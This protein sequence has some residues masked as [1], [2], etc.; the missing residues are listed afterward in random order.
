MADALRWL[1][2]RG[3]LAL[4]VQAPVALAPLLQSGQDGLEDRGGLREKV[5]P[6]V[7]AQEPWVR[8]WRPASRRSPA[9]EG[10]L[11]VF[12]QNR[13]GTVDLWF[14]TGQSSCTR[15]SGRLDARGLALKRLDD[16]GWLLGMRIYAWDQ[17]GYELEVLERLSPRAELGQTL[18]GR[19]RRAPAGGLL[20]A[21][22]ASLAAEAAAL[23]PYVG[24]FRDAEGGDGGDGPVTLACRP[25]LDGTWLF[26]EGRPGG[27]E[28]AGGAPFELACR[29]PAG[30]MVVHVFEG[31][32]TAREYRGRLD[33]AGA[34]LEA[35]GH[36]GASAWRRSDVF[37]QD[38]FTRTEERRAGPEQEWL[39][40]SSARFRRVPPGQRP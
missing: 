16:S 33:S 22:E 26:A 32:G 9:A 31:D 18:Y 5:R 1:G 34:L 4:T 7:E 29:E 15:W 38:G 21:P 3:A 28:S 14:F 19:Y 40:V 13:D 8:V 35:G 36:R 27:L 37:A 10:T 24:A 23:Q 6:V 17:D 39:V 20:S 30:G 2:F 11:E 12:R 25:A